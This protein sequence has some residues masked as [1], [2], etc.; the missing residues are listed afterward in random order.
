MNDELRLLS[1]NTTSNVGDNNEIETKTSE[2]QPVNT[3][4]DEDESKKDDDLNDDSKEDSKETIVRN[5]ELNGM[6]TSHL[7]IIIKE[8]ITFALNELKLNN[9]EIK[10]KYNYEN[11]TK[12]Y[13]FVDA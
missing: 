3:T 7:T 10:Q 5:D 11:F 2:T 4:S 1:F 12:T 8:Y 9:D 13:D 6:T